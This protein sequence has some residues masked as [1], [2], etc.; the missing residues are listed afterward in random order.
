MCTILNNTNGQNLCRASG[1]EL[2]LLAVLG[3]PQMKMKIDRELD[4]RARM[5]IAGGRGV[6]PHPTAMYCGHAA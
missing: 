4:R 2:L 5:D 3:S 1:E 6:V